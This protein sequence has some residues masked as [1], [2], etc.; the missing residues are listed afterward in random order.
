MS[1]SSSNFE[2]KNT[3]KLQKGKHHTRGKFEN[4]ED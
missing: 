1:F 3:F 2:L 4:M